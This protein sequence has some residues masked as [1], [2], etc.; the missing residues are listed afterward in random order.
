[1]DA[2]AQAFNALQDAIAAYTAA[3]CDGDVAMDWVL[4]VSHRSLT[5]D[6]SRVASYFATTSDFTHT[7]AALGLLSIGRSLVDEDDGDDL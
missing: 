4:V 6:D 7:H 3:A 1:M 5:E 2:Q